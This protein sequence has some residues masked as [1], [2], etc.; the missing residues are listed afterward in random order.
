MTAAEE[1]GRITGVTTACQV[2]NIPRSSF[3]RVASGA[4]HSERRTSVRS[5]QRS[6]Q[7]HKRHRA[8]SDKGK[9]QNPQRA[10]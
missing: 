5:S 1:L 3:Y 7:R 8:L 9:R 4:G 6:K 2:L 10:Q